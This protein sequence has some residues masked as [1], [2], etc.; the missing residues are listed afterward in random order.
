MLVTGPMGCH[1]WIGSNAPTKTW[2]KTAHGKTVK[3]PTKP[4]VSASTVRWRPFQRQIECRLALDPK[5]PV[6]GVAEEDRSV[7]PALC[8]LSRWAGGTLG[9]TS[10]WS[11]RKYRR[12]LRSALLGL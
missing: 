7:R 12:R 2:R 5:E 4:Q 8:A 1:Y 6:I 11:T 3:H 9:Y 10:F